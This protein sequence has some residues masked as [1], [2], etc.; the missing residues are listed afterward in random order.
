L[1]ALAIYRYNKG[2]AEKVFLKLHRGGSEMLRKVMLFFLVFIIS[3]PMFCV[4]ADEEI[5]VT[6][7]GERVNF[8][9]SPM[10]VDG[11]TLVPIRAVCEK[12][13]AEVDWDGN[14][15]TA[16]IS[17]NDT[18]LAL[19]I[20]KDRMKVNGEDTVYLDVPPAVYGGRTLL[21]IRAVAENLGCDVEWNSEGNHIIVHTSYI[22]RTP[23]DTSV[24]PL[25][26]K[27]D[28]SYKTTDIAIT[29]NITDIE[30]YSFYGHK[31]NLRSFSVDAGNTYFAVED[32]VLFNNDKTVLIAYPQGKTGSYYKIPDS[33]TEVGAAAFA[34]ANNLTDI[35]FGANLKIIGVDA[36]RGCKFTEI[37]IPD[38]VTGLWGCA[39]CDNENLQKITIPR[40]ARIVNDILSGGNPDVVVYGAA[41]SE[42]ETFAKQYGYRFVSSEL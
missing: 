7:D 29:D 35:D 39:F 5:T 36:F 15:K 22:I 2:I 24:L 23:Q 12:I 21:P 4:F 41:G 1:P 14:S 31:S 26:F 30:S 27:D 8:D 40:N 25:D 34:Y 11:R 28:I 33:V 18:T 20:G 17:Y 16:V 19:T 6:I 10:V 3:T 37:T 32:G 42:A 13:G 9:Q 38:T